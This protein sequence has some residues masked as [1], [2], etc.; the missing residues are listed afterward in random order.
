MKT[1]EPNIKILIARSIG[2]ACVVLTTNSSWIAH[3]CDSISCSCDDIGID[4]PQADVDGPFFLWEGAG[5]LM[6]ND[7]PDGYEPPEPDYIGTIRLITRE[8][9]PELL[10]MAPPPEPEINS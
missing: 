4:E 9:L 5:K 6:S 10:E 3:D 1:T 2:G 8:E 7:T